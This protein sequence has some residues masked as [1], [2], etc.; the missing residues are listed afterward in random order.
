MSQ[1]KRMTSSLFLKE[2]LKLTVQF[3]SGK[4]QLKTAKSLHK[5]IISMPLPV[6]IELVLAA[7]AVPLFLCR[8][9]DYSQQGFL[10][11]AR[12]YKN[13]FGW[14]LLSSGI[15]F[16]RPF[17]GNQFFS[18]VIDQFLT[19][20]YSTYEKYIE[21][22]ENEGT[23]LDA[24]FGTRIL[25][26]ATWPQLKNIH[27]TFGYGLRCNW[28]S[29]VFEEI[30]EKSPVIFLEIPNTITEY[31]QEMMLE[32]LNQSI[33]KLEQITGKTITNE[34]LRKQILLINKIR[35]SYL[36]IIELGSQNKIRLSPLSYANLLSLLHIG[37]TDCLSN[38]KFLDQV[39]QYLMKELE[40]IPVTGGFDTSLMPK[41]LLVNAFGGYEPHLPEIVDNLGGRLFV[42]DWDVFK[43][44][45]PIEP[46]GDILMNY[47]RA[48]LKF[49]SVWIDNT[50]LVERY[51]EVASKFGIDA[52]LFNNMYG[53]KSI[54][55]SLKLFKESL[56]D[57]DLAL[58]DIGFQNIGD[59]IEQVKT[60]IGAVL[61]IIRDRKK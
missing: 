5:K 4:K 43:L 60:R 15:Q 6:G 24:C 11:V 54:T 44:L 52:I 59:N 23:P 51:L 13:L 50:S 18:E 45:E 9:G 33:A 30:Q 16:L 21:I 31:S 7:D 39:L 25:L 1:G 48:L 22:A 37:F 27:G 40:K 53:C 58:V 17:V 34:K 57:T 3:F 42:A 12:L 47:A 8:V 20:L 32:S 2:F 49:E 46:N 56:Q 55:P 26:G 19:S 41:L 61:E 38:P 36:K 14:N 29:K 35:N 28:F 10:R